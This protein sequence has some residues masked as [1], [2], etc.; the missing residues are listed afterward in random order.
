MMLQAC[1]CL[2]TALLLL[3]AVP[4]G[5]A[6]PP[7]DPARRC[8]VTPPEQARWLGKQL[9]EQGAYQRAGECYQAAGDLALANLAFL[10]ALE[11]ETTTTERRLAEQRDQ[12][13]ALL[14]QVQRGLR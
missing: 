5:F 1:R 3:S 2:A 6:D 4:L 8:A 7:A 12:A 10:K 11:P 9:F 13:K 14:R